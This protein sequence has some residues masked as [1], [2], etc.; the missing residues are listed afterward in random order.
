GG[1]INLRVSNIVPLRNGSQISTR[2]GEKPSH[3]G[4][5]GNMNINAGFIVAVPEENSDITANANEGNGGNINITA[6]GIYGLQLNNTKQPLPISEITA[7][8]QLGIDGRVDINTPDVDPSRGLTQLPS[9]LSDPSN[10]IVAGCPADQ[11]NSFTVTGRGGIPYN[12]TEYLRG[13][14]VWQD[15]R[16]YE[17][18][19]RTAQ[20]L[21]YNEEL[22]TNNQTL[23]EAQGWVVDQDGTVILTAEPLRGEFTA[24]SS[25]SC[26]HISEFI[27]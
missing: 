12:P 19:D 26:E 10:Q 24:M 15:N 14:A 5:G 20:A 7:S 17:A 6:Q 27:E 8:S 22:T 13:R 25:Q 21:T 16:N 18:R 3:R 1:D 2:A 23:I 4:N 9:A 11:G